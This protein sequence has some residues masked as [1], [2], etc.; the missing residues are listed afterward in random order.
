MIWTAATFLLQLQ[1]MWLVTTTPAGKARII[2]SMPSTRKFLSMK[3]LHKKIL[4]GIL[5]NFKKLRITYMHFLMHSCWFQQGWCH[6]FDWRSC[7]TTLKWKSMVDRF[8]LGSRKWTQVGMVTY[9]NRWN[10]TRTITMGLYNQ[11]VQTMSMFNSCFERSWQCDV[12]GKGHAVNTF[13]YNL[14]YQQVEAH[15]L[16]RPRSSNVFSWHSANHALI[17]EFI[18]APSR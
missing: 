10:S 17:I 11:R 5:L 13:I 7:L 1:R 4:K 6:W 3:I 2:C 16:L 9:M 12:G 8:Q 18:N 15:C 14:L